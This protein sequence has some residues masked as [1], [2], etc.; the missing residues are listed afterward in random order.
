M[1]HTRKKLLQFK[2]GFEMNNTR[3]NGVATQ[4][5]SLMHQNGL[6]IIDENKSGKLSILLLLLKMNIFKFL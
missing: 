4:K 3:K 1:T 5:K 2:K 6:L